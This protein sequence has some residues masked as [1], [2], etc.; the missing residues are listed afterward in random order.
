MK[1]LSVSWKTYAAAE[2]GSVGILFA[3]LVVPVT[4]LAGGTVD[5]GRVLSQKSRVQSAAEAAALAAA[6]PIEAEKPDRESIAKTVFA[7]NL[8]R[9]GI[10]GV[11]PVVE[12]SA[13]VVTVTASSTLT[14]PF[15]NVMNLGD[16]PAN[17]FAQAVGGDAITND[18]PGKICMMGLDPS[19]TDG[20]HLQ[21]GNLVNFND[22]WSQSNSRMATAIN[23][24]GNSSFATG[25]GHC[26]VGSWTQTHT[27]FSPLPKA[28]CKEVA[29]PFAAVGA[30]V[31]GQD[32]VPAFTPP[33]K[34]ITCKASNLNLKKGTFT[35]DPGR[36][37]GGMK[38]QAGAKVTLNA[39]IYYM[40]DGEFLVQS[41]SSVTGSN[42]LLYFAGNAAKFTVIG[43]GTVDLKGRSTT[44]SY[45]GFLAIADAAA[46]RGGVSN[47][48]GGGVFKMQ[49]VIYMPTQ[50]IEVSGN[51][52]V[53]NA[54]IEFF[55]MVAKDFYFRGNGV[56]NMKKHTGGGNVPDIMPNM[57]VE[58]IRETALK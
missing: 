36:Y 52:D 46:N 29:D 21:G 22:C 18:S 3:M 38:I 9:S 27:T 26:A 19:S 24:S 39:G 13:T 31:E 56:F 28:A 33:N 6:R 48:Q 4:L 44:A 20:I 10:T 5:Y 51:G 2:K 30:Y 49:G 12:A 55:S 23:A 40:D 53:N 16:M 57:P 47:I 41:G 11:T 8:A 54:D 34:A 58:G 50:R 42:V 14:T 7:A 35:L 32:Y 43:G 37:C 1:R 17:A 15:L 45:A 25:K